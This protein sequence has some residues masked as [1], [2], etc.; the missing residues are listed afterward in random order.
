MGVVQREKQALCRKP[1]VGLDPGTPGSCSEPKA[2]A[3]PL[4]YPGCPT[5]L[6]DN[7]LL[8]GGVYRIVYMGVKKFIE[9]NKS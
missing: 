1:N 2:G 6:F 9:L 8:A 7:N 5:I 3:K 4:S